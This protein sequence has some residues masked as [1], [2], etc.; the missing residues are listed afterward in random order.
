MAKDDPE[1]KRRLLEA[2]KSTTTFSTEDPR[3]TKLVEDYAE[4]RKLEKEV[5]SAKDR[6]RR[7]IDDIF[8]AQNTGVIATSKGTLVG[9]P[10]SRSGVDQTLIPKEIL[11]KARTT[12]EYVQVD[13]VPPGAPLKKA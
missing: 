3:V 8:L 5:E 13:Y 12:T 7:E 9:V 2:T 11:D 6:L 4:F 1:R 10:R